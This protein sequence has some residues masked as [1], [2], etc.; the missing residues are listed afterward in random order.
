MLEAAGAAFAASGF[1]AASMDEIAQ[2]AAISKPMLYNYFG[3]KEGL[4]IAYVRRSGQ[5]LLQ[6]MRAAGSP[7][8]PADARLRAGV[9]AF[10]AY[11]DDHRSGWAVL[12]EE[13][14]SR[15][16]PIAAEVAELRARIVRMLSL[17]FDSAAFAHAFVGASE[18]LANW[19]LEHSEVSK[20]E[21][22]EMLGDIAQIARPASGPPST[23]QTTRRGAT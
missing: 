5:A 13:A 7:H 17:L 15:G 10:L 6:S 1:H 20:E 8:A 3:S 18:S 11:V 9:L 16:G 23:G 14:S 19:W 22:A 21:I 2:A 4:Y 12:H